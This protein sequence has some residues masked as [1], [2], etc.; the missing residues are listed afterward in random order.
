MA[1]ELAELAHAVEGAHSSLQL[2]ND[3]HVEERDVR[4]TR[5]STTAHLALIEARL[6]L[7]VRV[8]YGSVDPAVLLTAFNEGTREGR[9]PGDADFF[10]SPW[11][12]STRTHRAR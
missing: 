5:R 2:I 11:P 8:L 4:R 3:D 1:F 7:L 10:L 12:R 9:D 6:R